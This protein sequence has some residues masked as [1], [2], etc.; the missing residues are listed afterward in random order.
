MRSILLYVVFLF[1]PWVIMAQEA[2]IITFN[3]TLRWLTETSFPN[4][5]LLRDVRD[6]INADIQK[7]LVQQFNVTNVTFPDKVDYHIINGFGKPK[8]SSSESNNSAGYDAEIYS[9]L[10]RAT[11]G[12]AVFWSVNVII[13]KDGNIVHQKEV[14]H[15]I[16]NSNISAYMKEVRW[17]SPHE[18]QKIFGELFREAIGIGGDYSAK[19][20][21]GD[22]MEKEKEMRQW[23]PGSTRYLLKKNGAWLNA[24]NFAAQMMNDN[25]T[26]LQFGYRN[27]LEFKFGKI[28]LKPIL[29]DLFTELTGLGSTYSITEKERKRGVL[30][31]SGGKNLQIEMNW[32]EEVTAFNITG[33]TKRQITVPLVG[34]IYTD[35]TL[36][37]NFIYEKITQTLVSDQTR[38]KFSW[39][40][41]PYNENSFGT[42][43]IHRVKGNLGN[44]PFTAE[45]NE[46]FG[47]VE[48]KRDNQTL[49]TM[50]VQNC[51]PENPNSFDK[52]RISKNKSVISESGSNIGKPSIGKGSKPE[53][54]PF[55]VKANATADDM[56]TGVGIMVCLFFGI[57]NM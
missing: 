10:T 57:G 47:L 49:A 46:L 7:Y 30:E 48:I 27:R 2:R 56:V 17:V 32:I 31:F 21:V 16:E 3:H 45:Y 54:Y 11:T 43:V 29:A 18:F 26:V 20:I 9:F 42:V 23:F 33:E 15:E 6:T 34:Q 19:I 24:G 4:Y 44:K 1:Q 55:F 28:S 37:G 39:A 25:D 40:S 41:G 50:I 53:W 51:N 52:M 22:I 8:Y 35:T 13:R 5:F 14:R 38:E 12:K 36:V